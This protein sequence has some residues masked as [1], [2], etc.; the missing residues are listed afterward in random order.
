MGDLEPWQNADSSSPGQLQSHRQ[1]IPLGELS[2]PF[3]KADLGEARPTMA[4]SSQ[5][6]LG[7]GGRREGDLGCLGPV[8]WWFLLGSA[9]LLGKECV[10]GGHSLAGE[11]HTHPGP[12]AQDHSGQRTHGLGQGKITG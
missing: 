11:A 7:E 3:L 6:S 4:R 2:T 1:L 5:W 12:R 8:P 9:A 10:T